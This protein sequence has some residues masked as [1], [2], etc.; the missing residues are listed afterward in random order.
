MGAMRFERAEYT[1]RTTGDA[2]LGYA[3]RRESRLDVEHFTIP[4]LQ[5]LGSCLHLWGVAAGLG[6][7]AAAGQPGV[8]VAPGVAVDAAGRMLS[9]APGGAVV[10]DAAVSLDPDLVV[11]VP[12][13]TVTATGVALGTG[14][15]T[16]DRFV[17]VRFKQAQQENLDG[18]EIRVVHAPLLRLV[19]VNGF[20]DDGAA[21][22]LARV[23]LTAGK[24][25]AVAAGPRRLA[26]LPAGAVELRRVG[27]APF[28]HVVAG[29]LGARTDGGIELSVTAADG[30]QTPA[31]TVG[32]DS[33]VGVA[34]DLEVTGRFDAAR[35]MYVHESAAGSAGVWFVQDGAGER[36]F[37]GMV[38]D[39]TVGLWGNNGAEW[40]LTMKTDT[41]EVQAG[42]G[43]GTGLTG[44]G[45]DESA[46]AGVWGIG[47]VGVWASARG[48]DGVGLFAQGG[49]WTPGHG[50]LGRFLHSG[51]AARFQGDVEISGTLSKGGGGFKIDHPLDP[52]NQYLSHSFVESPDMLNVYSGN[53]TTDDNGTATV[54]LPDYFETLNA[55]HCYQLTPIGRL[56]QAAVTSPI[57]GNTFTIQTSEPRTTVSW[58]VTGIR[59]DPWSQAHRI[60]VEEAK[61][62]HARN[63]YLH[64]HLIDTDPRSTP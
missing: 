7:S 51:T 2:L 44:R 35:R 46:D 32:S 47:H 56:A 9:I 33:K 54:H 11:D 20:L 49:R 6:V 14:G 26:G 34:K 48:D 53:V 39:D 23:S 8:Q 1:D 3:T 64:P 17:I 27:A 62:E 31:V 60:T 24:V 19:E 61:P 18:S 10:T 5:V 12:T 37:V 13:V 28:D 22:V 15:V 29:R 21:L 52:A 55:E 25:A 36:G 30:S 4:Q 43:R 45:G 57:A 42:T 40:G 58:Q 16:G 41:G 38:D 63:T 59:Q 50:G